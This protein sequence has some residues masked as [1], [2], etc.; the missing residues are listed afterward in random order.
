MRKVLRIA[1]QTLTK[2][3]YLLVW[4]D[5]KIVVAKNVKI[6]KKN[7]KALQKDVAAMEVEA[8]E[9]GKTSMRKSDVGAD[10]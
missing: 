3:A 5:D 4:I 7:A 1:I 9:E 8:A 6:A 2:L 10:L